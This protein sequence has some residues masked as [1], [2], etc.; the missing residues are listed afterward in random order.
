MEGS[1]LH[2][3]HPS[4]ARL[5]GER[6]AFDAALLWLNWFGAKDTGLTGAKDF[7]EADK[8]QNPTLYMLGRLE[9]PVTLGLMGACILAHV[10]AAY[11]NAGVPRSAGTATLGAVTSHTLAPP[12][13]LVL[14]SHWPTR[15]PVPSL[16]REQIVAASADTARAVNRAQEGE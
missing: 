9:K 8:E 5:W 4:P 11:Y 12:M 6:A 15:S 14:N 2:G 1:D 7:T 13:G 16:N 10:H 3:P